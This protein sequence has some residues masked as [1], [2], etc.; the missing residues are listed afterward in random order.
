MQR[1]DVPVQENGRMILPLKLRR[2]LGLQKGDRVILQAEGDSVR[3]TTAR[4]ARRQA[5]ARF[6]RLVPRGEG[7]VDAFIEEKR[8]EVAR[9]AAKD[10]ERGS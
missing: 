4:L 8:A 6:R 2:A 9:E 1:Y 7:V 5:Q 3:L 10:D